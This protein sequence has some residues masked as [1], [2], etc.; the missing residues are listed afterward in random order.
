M[1]CFLRQIQ[2]RSLLRGYTGQIAYVSLTK[3]K[4]ALRLLIEVRK[5]IQDRIFN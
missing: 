1:T 3:R 4:L 2:C 5:T